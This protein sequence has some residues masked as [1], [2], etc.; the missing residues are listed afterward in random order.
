MNEAKATEFFSLWGRWK[1]S[2]GF[3]VVDKLLGERLPPWCFVGSTFAITPSS[4]S[5]KSDKDGK[6]W[7]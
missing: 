1:N 3:G 2:E 5:E 7:T 4:L 6:L